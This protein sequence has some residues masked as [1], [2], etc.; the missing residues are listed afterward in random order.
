VRKALLLATLL[1]SV[2]PSSPRP[3]YALLG[4]ECP[5]CDQLWEQALQYG[6]Q[7]QEYA[8][9]LEQLQTELSM[10]TN[11]VRNSISIPMQMF[12]QVQSDIAQVQTI[13]NMA[14]LLTGNS[15]SIISRLN[16]LQSAGYQ[17]SSTANS[18]SNLPQ[19]FAM[20]QNTIGNSSKQLATAIGLQQSELSNQATL[21]TAIQSHSQSAA[22]QL[23]AI[24]AG[25][26][27]AANNAAVL[28]QISQT[29]I[30]TAQAAQTS[31]AVDADRRASEDAALLHFSTPQSVSTTGGQGF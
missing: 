27:M 30:A 15:G 21:Q 25:N 20:W 24:Q 17:I 10:Y 23:Q 9:Q 1:I 29:L 7:I 26:E 2:M 8:T 11:M 18:I 22:G 31:A 28:H 5:T 14:G 19:Q 16:S 6:K 3:A 4:V 12:S 13:S